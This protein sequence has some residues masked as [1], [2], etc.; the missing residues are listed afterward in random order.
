MSNFLNATYRFLTTG[1]QIL[2][3]GL[4]AVAGLVV[5]IGVAWGLVQLW[6]LPILVAAT[7]G[8]LC[9][10]L[11][12]YVLHELWTFQD[13]SKRLSL[14]RLMA[15]LLGLWFVLGVRMAGVAVLS[16]LL[17][18]Q[19][20]LILVAATGLSFCANYLVSK[21]LIFRRTKDKEGDDRL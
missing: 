11:L 7:V 21:S 8:F 15:Y 19:S 18:G 9:G 3:F 16:I 5:D 12:N 20:L 6:A 10:A 13:S 4:V 2:R 17:P 1:P 14:A